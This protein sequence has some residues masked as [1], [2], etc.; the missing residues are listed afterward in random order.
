MSLPLINLINISNSNSN[1][2]QDGC[3]RDGE[4]FGG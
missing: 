2:F 4:G 1:I 3:P